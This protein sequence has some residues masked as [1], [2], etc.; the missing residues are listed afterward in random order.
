MNRNML[1]TALPALTLTGAA[2]ALLLFPTQVSQAV[3]D[4]IGLCLDT[5][6][7]NL[8][9]FFILSSLVV[10]LGLSQTIGKALEPMMRPLFRLPGSCSTALVLGMIGGYPTGAKTAAALYLEGQCSKQ[11]TERLLS[12]CNNCGPAFLLG[13][14]GS[15]CFGA[16]AY[17]L[18]LTGVHI[19]A[20]LLTGILLNQTATEAPTRTRVDPVPRP[21]IALSSAFVDSV[22]DAMQAMLNLSAFVLCFCAISQMLELSSLS[23]QLSV[24]LFPYLSG[25]NGTVLLSG[26]LEMSRGV[27]Q[28]SHGSVPERLMLSAVLLGWGGLS[29]HCQTLSLLRDT[30]LSPAVYFKGKTL[31]ALLSAALMAAVVWQAVWVWPM[32]GIVCLYRPKLPPKKSSGKSPERI[33]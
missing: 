13:V 5:L 31:H 16:P 26:L 30:G 7:P 2:L 32:L 14:V 22:T 33:L 12:F 9:P 28:L 21:P 20:A 19:S 3:R 27:V 25:E 8:F 23:E 18:L 11:E 29:V 24:I 17:G 6:L 1:Q 4:G 15:G 10:K